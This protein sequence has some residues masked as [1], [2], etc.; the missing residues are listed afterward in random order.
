MIKTKVGN[1]SNKVTGKMTIL[2]HL[3]EL[4]RRIIIVLGLI[5]V[6]FVIN[7]YYSRHLIDFLM[8]PGK[9]VQFMFYNPSEAFLANLRG[10]FVISI[11]INFPFIIYH[12]ISFILPAFQKQ[13]K[14]AI[15]IFIFLAVLLFYLGVAFSFFVVTP[16]ALDFL[17]GF[18][19]ENLTAQISIASYLTFLFNS[20]FAF[21]IVFQTPIIFTMLAK[22]SLISSKFMRKNWKYA[23]LI[24]VII[25]A[26][27]T[28]PDVFSQILMSIPLILLFEISILLVYLVEKRKSR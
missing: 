23:V 6:A 18:S 20:M 14:I 28:P 13:K 17:V 26:I 25:S 1:K 19:R 2:E 24:I 11:L 15:V 16:I 7:I 12:L 21:G 8:Y 5:A 9:N 4:R 10:A 27:I 22:M 3:E